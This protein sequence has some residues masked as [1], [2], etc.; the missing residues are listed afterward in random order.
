VYN[1]WGEKVFETKDAAKGWNG[2]YN[3][4]DQINDVYTWLC[5][6]QFA[7]QEKK[8]QKGSVVLIK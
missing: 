6:Y 4:K 1:R 3:G 8:S 7:G 2:T 5:T